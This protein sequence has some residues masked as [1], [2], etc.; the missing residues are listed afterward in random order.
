MQTIALED[1]PATL[2]RNGGGLTR[3]LA[4]AQIGRSEALA[5]LESFD[6]RL[7]VADI[8]ADGPFSSFPGV[9]RHAVLLGA[10]AVMLSGP[11]GSAL[12]MPLRPVSFPGEAELHAQRQSGTLQ[13]RFL[14]LMVRR[15]V[16]RGEL[17]IVD[18]ACQVDDAVAWAL[19]PVTGRWQLQGTEVLCS[20]QVG[21]SGDASVL[22]ARPV[23]ADSKA[24][25]VRI[26]SI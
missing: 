10:G 15:S 11:S 24:V 25:L 21:L 3:L 17:R 12:A 26:H 20:G 14:N 8:S 6:W 1:V 23:E 18:Q 4:S 2:W 22:Q 5:H 9:D 7:S 19:L 13:P 16:L